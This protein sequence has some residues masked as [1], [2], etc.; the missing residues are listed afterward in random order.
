MR[1]V[2]SLTNTNIGRY[3]GCQT[4]ITR[5]SPGLTV[6]QL[7]TDNRTEEGVHKIFTSEG[8][9]YQGHQD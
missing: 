6:H 2:Y 4:A 5:T 1:V 8:L 7:N 9:P 3:Q